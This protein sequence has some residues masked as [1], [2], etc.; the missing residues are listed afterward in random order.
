MALALPVLLASQA[1]TLG[2]TGAKEVLGASRDTVRPL[3]RTLPNRRWRGFARMATA[4]SFRPA[5]C[6]LSASGR[7]RYRALQSLPVRLAMYRL[8]REKEA[9]Q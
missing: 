1:G 5:A 9:T 2:G 8:W 7:L 4:G 3:P 6:G